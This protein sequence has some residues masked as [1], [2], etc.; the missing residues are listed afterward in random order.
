MNLEHILASSVPRQ[1]V[2]RQAIVLDWDEGPRNGVCALAEPRGEFFFHLFAESAEENLL[3]IRLFAVS[4]LEE[5]TV[6]K[7]EALLRPLGQPVGPLWIPAWK[8]VEPDVRLEIESHLDALVVAARPTALLTATSDWLHFEGC[9]NAE[10]IVGKSML[11]A[12]H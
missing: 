5:G 1:W 3:G 8:L 12:A 4:E 10:R 9:W 6:A 7:I 11:S 2:T